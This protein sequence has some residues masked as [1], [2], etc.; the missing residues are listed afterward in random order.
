MTNPTQSLINFGS[1]D[2]TYPVAGQDNNSQ[3]FRDNFGAIKTG[4]GQASTEITALQNNAAF[5]NS[6]NDFGGNT[7]ANAVYNKFFGATIANGTVQSPTNI[8]INNGPVQSVVLGGNVALTFTN[9]PT[10]GQY[11]FVKLLVYSDGNGVRTPT[12]ATSNA[13]VFKYD[14]AFPTLSG[15]PGFTVGGEVVTAVGIG[16]AGTGYTS[17]TTV[18][19]SGGGLQTNG[20]QATGTASYTVV[21]ASVVGGYAGNGYAVGDTL[22][23]NANTG[24]V[25][26]VNSLNLTFTASTTNGQTTLTNVSN[27]TNISNG[28]QI[29]GAGIPTGTTISSFNATAQTITMSAQATAT[30]NNIPVTYVSSTGPIGSLNV[31]SGGT[32]S[33]PL[34]AVSNP[35]WDTNPLIGIG[36][37]A[38][39]VLTTG[40]GA[41]TITSPGV[42]YTSSPNVVFTGGGGVNTVATASIS[43]NTGSDPKIIE[44]WTI[45]G[46]SHVYMKFLGTYH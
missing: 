40:I 32:Q 34:S 13:G 28:L 29:S 12:F 43:S 45:D 14:T 33:V 38:R 2:A 31:V 7:I 35:S 6:N 26:S 23:V 44:A 11:A 4:L 5:V 16:A 3:G 10:T 27:F 8:N 46:G 24:I 22:V 17:A 41:V 1:I 9:W 20:V 21:G 37:G 42:G 15:T 30:A 25:L 39:V 19:F 36:Y 18:S